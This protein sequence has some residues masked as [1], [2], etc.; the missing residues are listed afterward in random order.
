MRNTWLGLAAMAC[1]LACAPALAAGFDIIAGPSV[2][3]SERST[4]A[5]FASVLGEPPDGGGGSF[6]SPHAARARRIEDCSNH[7][8]M[9]GP[10]PIGT[11]SA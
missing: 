11:R 6:F 8:R 3:S 2:T 10:Y 9:T 5:A 1:L 4:A 7:R